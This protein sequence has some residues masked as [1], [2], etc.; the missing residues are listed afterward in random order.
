MLEFDVN[1]CT[2]WSTIKIKYNK[3]KNIELIKTLY[4]VGWKNWG[5]GNHLDVLGA[6][7]NIILI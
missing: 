4:R 2:S 5:D 3:C 1:W 6:D 7:I